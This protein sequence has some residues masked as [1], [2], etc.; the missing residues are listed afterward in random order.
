MKRFFSLSVLLS[1]ILGMFITTYAQN[2]RPV[3]SWNTNE[4]TQTIGGAQLVSPLVVK[5]QVSKPLTDVNIFVVP[6]IRRFVTVQSSDLSNLQPSSEYSL[7]LLF[8]VPTQ[9]AE[10]VTVELFTYD[11]ATRPSLKHSRLSKCQLCGKLA[12]TK[13]SNAVRPIRS[14]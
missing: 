7:T 13:R 9:T 6:E 8:S 12:L 2:N 10:G 5:F 3:V 14:V 1:L 11:R 4:I